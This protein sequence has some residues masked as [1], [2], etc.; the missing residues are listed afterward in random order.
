MRNARTR[1]RDPALCVQDA[2]FE[3]IPVRIYRPKAPSAAGPRKGVVYFHG[4]G[5]IFGSLGE[6]RRREVSFL[7]RERNAGI[8]YLAETEADA[9]GEETGVREPLSG[10]RGLREG[11]PLG[12]P[13]LQAPHRPHSTAQLPEKTRGGG[14]GRLNVAELW[15]DPGEGDKREALKVSRTETA[16]KLPRR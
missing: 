3:G 15:E 8:S 14:G 7:R 16:R 11:L 12:T 13:S 1:R 2:A 4:G 10:G 5:W 6:P 9:Q